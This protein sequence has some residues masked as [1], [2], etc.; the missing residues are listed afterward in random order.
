MQVRSSHM[1]FNTSKSTY[2]IILTATIPIYNPNF[3]QVAHVGEGGGLGGQAEA[4]R[5]RRCLRMHPLWCCVSI[6]VVARGWRWG[7]RGGGGEELA[8]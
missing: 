7:P 2:Q 5:E 8:G 3:L 6:V 1:S 4:G